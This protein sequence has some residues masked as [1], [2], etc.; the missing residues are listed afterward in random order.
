M[1]FLFLS[2]DVPSRVISLYGCCLSRI[3]Y[4]YFFAYFLVMK[5]PVAPELII[6]IFFFP[7]IL[8]AILKYILVAV[9][10]G[11]IL[12]SFCWLFLSVK[13]SFFSIFYINIYSFCS[14]YRLNRIQIIFLFDNILNNKI[15]YILSNI[16]IYSCQ[17][18]RILLLVFFIAI[19]LIRI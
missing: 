8:I 14:W 18:Y 4:F 5:F 10:S 6:A 11:A 9:V 19:I 15:V 3:K 16:F 12:F 17:A 13:F 2:N 7:L 1:I